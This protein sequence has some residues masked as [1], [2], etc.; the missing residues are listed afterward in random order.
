MIAFADLVIHGTAPVTSGQASGAEF[1][2]EGSLKPKAVFLFQRA[3]QFG[4]TKFHGFTGR[5][6]R[7][8]SSLAALP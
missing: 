7:L 4:A 8:S 5:Y 1:W 6:E 3:P 2:L